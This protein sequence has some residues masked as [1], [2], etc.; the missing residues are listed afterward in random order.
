MFLIELISIHALVKRAT[1]WCRFLL[2]LPGISIHALV[3]RATYISCVGLTKFLISIHALVKRA[4]ST[5]DA[6][7]ELIKNFNP[8]PREEGDK[9]NYGIPS[10]VSYFNPRPREEGDQM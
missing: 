9:Y 4:T 10:T 8:R 2:S 5:G 6:D 3:K 1:Y 7:D